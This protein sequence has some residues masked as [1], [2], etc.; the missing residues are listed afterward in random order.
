MKKGIEIGTL[1]FFV[2]KEISYPFFGTDLSHKPLEE[3]GTNGSTFGTNWFYWSGDHR[4]TYG[5]ESSD[6]RLSRN[7]P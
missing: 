2:Q 7:R 1:L 5:T 4:E 3:K 6:S